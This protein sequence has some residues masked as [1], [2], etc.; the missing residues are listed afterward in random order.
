MGID[1]IRL[2]KTQSILVYFGDRTIQFESLYSN[3]V[4]CQCNNS[5]FIDFFSDIHLIENIK[6]I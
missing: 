5:G 4:S 6:F 1:E 2:V 3:N